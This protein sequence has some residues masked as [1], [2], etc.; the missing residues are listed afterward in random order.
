MYD[1]IEI[2]VE[3]YACVNS[4]F[5]YQSYTYCILHETSGSWFSSKICCL[6]ERQYYRVKERQRAEMWET[7][8]SDFHL[9]SPQMAAT[10][11]V[12]PG[13]TQELKTP[14][15]FPCGR[16]GPKHFIHLYWFLRPVAGSGLVSRAAG[17]QADA[18]I[19]CW[20][21]RWLLNMLYHN[22]QPI[23]DFFLYYDIF[24]PS[25]QSRGFSPQMHSIMCKY[26]ILYSIIPLLLDISPS[27]LLLKE[28][29][30]NY[31]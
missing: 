26:L 11:R 13:W 29:L 31:L 24:C 6:F 22:S 8:C 3:Y 30:A 17:T 15:G 1:S 14:S 23:M 4:L 20:R 19:G 28:S 25:L 21:C 7:D 18:D 12:G 27:I 9:L 5:V 10:T 16:Q 2:I